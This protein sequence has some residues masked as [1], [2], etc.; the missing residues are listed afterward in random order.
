MSVDSFIVGD[1]GLVSLDLYCAITT[2]KQEKAWG[3]KEDF[4]KTF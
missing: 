4:K 2:S 1:V 3:K